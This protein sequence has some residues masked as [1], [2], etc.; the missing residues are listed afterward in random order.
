[1]TPTIHV[2]GAGLSGLAAA[3]RVARAGGRAIVY[4]AAGHAGGRCRS[5]FDA[6]LERRIDNGNH[7]VLSGNQAVHDYLN[8]LGATAGLTG[9]DRA[10]FPFIDLATGE[11]WC[12][13]PGRSA[14]PW[15]I[16]SA[17]RRIPGTRPGDYL[18]ALRLAFADRNDTVGACVGNG[19]LRHRFWE[20]LTEA[21]L[22]ASV[23]EAAACLLWPVLRET[24]GRGEAACRPRVAREGLS[25]CFVDPALAF[26]R[27]SGSEVLLHAR[28][29][30]IVY[31]GGRATRLV[32]TG[33]D[34]RAIDADSAVIV[35]VPPQ[36]AVDLIPG[37]VSPQG[38]RAIL[39]VHYRLPPGATAEPAILGLVG[40]VCHWLFV[41]GDVASVTVSA[42]DPLLE[43]SGDTLAAEI[44][45]EVAKTL[46]LGDI[47]L[48]P[49][50]MIREKRAT[51]LQT[52]A[53][54]ARRPGCETTWPNLFL[55]GDWTNTG[56]PATIEGSV[57]SGNSAGAKAFA[58][59]R[60][61]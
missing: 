5:F 46:N 25:E 48:P 53:Q 49:F 36:G 27:R 18:S 35:A 8:A 32:F 17:Q 1:V 57:R 4:E 7:L 51:F 39:N 2:I 24:F 12:V 22:N 55:A 30:S 60:H 3:V 11:R 23:E 9:P 34:A 16:L 10:E 26:L 54:V 61:A 56:I 50:R 37:L 52:P 28:V 14:V 6:T 47:P 21:V 19:V 45:Q 29:R 59:L 31:D 20:P 13:R 42:A 58:S 41:R 44:W 15:W 38:H 43:R 33:G 40:G